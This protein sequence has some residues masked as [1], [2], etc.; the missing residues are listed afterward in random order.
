MV[1]DYCFESTDHFAAQLMVVT[2]RAVSGEM[3]H[4]TPGR[5]QHTITQCGLQRDAF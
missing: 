2:G 5:E 1:T 3:L 4:P